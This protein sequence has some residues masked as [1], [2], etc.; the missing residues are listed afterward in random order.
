MY[1]CNVAA[2]RRMP[3]K[4]GGGSTTE[5][6]IFPESATLDTFEWR[7]SMAQ[8]ANSG[9]F[10]QFAGIDRSLFLVS[11]G[12]MRLQ[13]EGEDVQALHDG[14]PPCVFCG[15]QQGHAEIDR[16]LLDFNVMSRRGIWQHQLRRL[17][18][19]KHRAEWRGDASLLYCATGELLL[20]ENAQA[21]SAGEFILLESPQWE[22]WEVQVNGVA[23][24]AELKRV[25]T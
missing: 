21:L 10:S 22:T 1:V 14:S 9:S 24:V 18:D 15:E 6:A 19:G 16:P 8:V 7:I 17:Q 11:E 12:I 5:L 4:N 20:R 3:W 23:Y 13:F 25:A 2:C